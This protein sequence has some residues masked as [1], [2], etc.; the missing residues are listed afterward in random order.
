MKESEE[1]Y[2]PISLIDK[3]V[4]DFIFALNE[5]D[6]HLKEGYELAVDDMHMYKIVGIYKKG[7]TIK[8]LIK[9]I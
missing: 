4:Q 8:E 5:V 9:K 1:I 6:E 2:I 7:K 3:M